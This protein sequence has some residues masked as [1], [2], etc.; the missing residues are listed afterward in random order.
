VYFD[1]SPLSPDPSDILPDHVT[2]IVVKFRDDFLA[3]SGDRSLVAADDGQ[4]S[5]RSHFPSSQ[6]APVFSSLSTAQLGSLQAEAEAAAEG[7]TVPKLATYFAVTVPSGTEA[8]GLV[9]EAL[10]IDG[11]EHAYV[12]GA[13]TIPPLVKADDDPRSSNQ[14]Y[15]DAA[16]DGIDARFA[17]DI[18]G[19]DG[20]GA[21]FVDLEQG[22]TLNHED[23]TGAK[24]K[25]ISGVN[26]AFPG[27]GTAVLGEVLAQDN[28]TGGV[29]I[30]PK[31]SARVISQWRTAT[32]FNTAD[33][34]L[35][36]VV[37]MQRGDVLLLEAQTTVA[38]STFLPVEVED[39][40]Y[41][42]ILVATIL[43]RVVV[44]AGGNGGNDL[45]QYTDATHGFILQRGHADFRDSGAIM[46]GAASSTAP[47]SRL[48]F[49]NYG[50]RIDCYAWGQNI[51]TTGDG[52]QGTAT[53]LYTTSFGGTSGASPIV[54]GAA[55]ALQGMT[56]SKSGTPYTPWRLRELLA[57]SMLGT[58]SANPSTD[59]IG[60]MPDLRAIANSESLAP[61]VGDFP[62]PK[63]DYQ[64]AGVAAVVDPA[65]GGPAPRARY[66]RPVDR[67]AVRIE[68]E[69]NLAL[70]RSVRQ[71]FRYGAR[72]TRDRDQEISTEQRRAIAA[73]AKAPMLVSVHSDT[74]RVDRSGPEIWVYGGAEVSA[75][76]PSHQLAQCIGRELSALDGRPVPVHLGQVSILRPNTGAPAA[77]CVVQAGSLRRADDRARL[78]DPAYQRELGQAIARGMNAY[79][80]FLRRRA[81]TAMH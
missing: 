28:T 1:G 52:W 29:G 22:W 35:A 41:V 9:S 64:Y 39:A 69:I 30:V 47:H 67:E 45:D 6:I 2:R 11:V 73:R 8:E 70:A 43:G 25:L 53:N 16:P 65:H 20:Q 50:S 81:S 57:D 37:A 10:A 78:K 72:L 63:G 66:G 26:Q 38:G 27:H 4:G 5:L 18:G 68:Q 59:M 61:P 23:L 17:W 51:D 14:G 36:A 7:Q 55:L 3:P 79:A 80:E 74:G 21:R 40:V 71:G 19:G 48:N 62:V 46:V 54:T 32:V 49:S 77:A 60:V 56:L 44:E 15:L 76:L 34:I 33:A 24:I 12:E 13:P 31:V 42:A 58:A 75:G